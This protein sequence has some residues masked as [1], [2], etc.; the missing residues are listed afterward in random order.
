[1]T[2]NLAKDLSAARVAQNLTFTSDSWHY[3]LQRTQKINATHE[4]LIWYMGSSNTYMELNFT[5]NAWAVSHNYA[6]IGGDQKKQ[7]RV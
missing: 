7:C 5:L 6:F 3:E 2:G 1:M 4:E